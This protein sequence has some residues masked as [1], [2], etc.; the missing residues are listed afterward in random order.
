MYFF[1]TCTFVALILLVCS[2]KSYKQLA[3]FQDLSDTSRV[4]RV[5]MYPYK[6]I[7]IQVDDQLQVSITST[8][9]EAAI[10]FQQ[11]PSAGTAAS[12]PSYT[13][14]QNGNITMPVLGDI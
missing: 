4:Q 1:R 12:L 3:Y 6:P 7:L 2:C 14:F 11:A 9:P 8:S 5:E 13:V 10:Y